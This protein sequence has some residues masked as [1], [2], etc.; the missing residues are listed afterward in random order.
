MK[1]KNLF[2][3]TDGGNIEILC[4]R[5]TWE[6]LSLR[7]QELKSVL[8]APKEETRKLIQAGAEKVNQTFNNVRNT[9]GTW[10]QKLKSYPSRI[11][12]G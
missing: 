12:K 8:V 11:D 6:C 2:E 1:S 3:F 4:C 10:S 7:S 9:F 5:L